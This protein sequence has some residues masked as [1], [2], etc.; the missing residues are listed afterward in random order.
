MTKQEKIIQIVEAMTMAQM[1]TII[2][3]VYDTYPDDKIDA[4]HEEF[5]KEVDT[6]EGN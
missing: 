1:S 4:W 5:L 3:S 6:K 2:A